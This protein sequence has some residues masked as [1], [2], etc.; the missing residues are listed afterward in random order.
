MTTTAIDA[1]RPAASIQTYARVAGVLG[2][3]SIV[4]G[5]FGEAY[6]PSQLIVHTDAMATARNIIESDSLFRWGFASYL[7]EGLCD[8]AL[9]LVLFILLR[10]VSRDLALLVTFFR[11]IAT[12]GFAM[13]ESFYFAASP[14]VTGADHLNAFSPDQLN[15]L[16]LL[17]LKVS[18]HGLSIF[19]MFYGVAAMLLGYLIFRSGFLP[20]ILGVLLALSGGLFVIKTFASVLAPAYA[21]PILLAPAG[22]AWLALT[23]WLL[24]KGVDVTKWQRKGA[25]YR[26]A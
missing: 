19:M 13:S 10:P 9:T 1:D 20:R 14:I 22:L 2:L 7:I 11:L 16:A 17:S 8:V 18:G 6:V 5:G 25:A 26:M 4:A 12:A 24:V 21:S 15:T 3:V 23:L